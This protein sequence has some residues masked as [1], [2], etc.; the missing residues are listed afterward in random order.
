MTQPGNAE[1]RIK[2]V[3]DDQ[4]S[5]TVKKV[6]EGLH[7]VGEEAHKTGSGWDKINEGGGKFVAG[8]L[9][10]GVAAAGLLT[11]ALHEGY[12]AAKMLGD[13]AVEAANEYQKQVKAMSGVLMLIDSG[14]HSMKDIKE[15]AADIHEELELTAVAM[16][17]TSA[18]MD[19]AF[20]TLMERGGLASEQAKELTADMALVG[21]VVRGGMEGLASGFSMI[22][23]GVVR[24]RNPIVQL[25]AATHT[26][27]G[28]AHQVAAAM[29]KMTPEQQME[30]AEKAISKQAE[31]MKK[32]GTPTLGL[33]GLKTSMGG[34]REMFLVSMGKPMLD[35]LLPPLNRVQ[36]FL[37]AH[38][39]KITE[40]GTSIGLVFSKVI[41]IVVEASSGIYD[42]IVLSWDRVKTSF[43]AIFGDWVAAWN[44]AVSDSGNIR[45]DFA[46]TTEDLIL[47]FEL[48]AKIVKAMLEGTTMM[49]EAYQNLAHT[50]LHPVDT[51]MGKGGTVVGGAK[52]DT[53][54]KAM[55]GRAH[56]DLS[57]EGTVAFEKAAANYR[58]L[59]AATGVA[60]E[61]AEQLIASQRAQREST[62]ATFAHEAA[63]AE[64][65]QYQNFNQQ[66]QNAVN[67]HD[68]GAEK[69]ALSYIQNSGMLKQALVNGGIT[70]AG[71]MEAMMK[72]VSEESPELARQLAEMRKA[73]GIGADR[74]GITASRTTNVN[75][76]GGIQIKQDF[77][78][79][80]PDRIALV[81]RDDVARKALTATSAKTS[82]LFGL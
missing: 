36:Q 51:A 7:H 41:N 80:D 66:L 29:Q 81:F 45:K 44:V 63:Q 14:K 16:G 23:M 47:A 10:A 2:L 46:K 4:T 54:E 78:D 30:M 1:V 76:S 69:L 19:E 55:E 39:E 18:A 73:S 75:I 25:I 33:D 26:L 62:M 57:A 32:N 35:A 6:Q 22:E 48:G 17:Q 61:A 5:A 74:V 31:L 53:A 27:Q 40:W 49:V 50:I 56:Q 60:S 9:L 24:A 67:A 11:V 65:G 20:N 12:E 58:K 21:K 42:G 3:A 37:V 64:G 34:V 79:Q 59:A 8:G 43:D 77:R 72:V 82:S 15:Y 52:R 28:N 71:G 13:A 68:E 70:I 38:I